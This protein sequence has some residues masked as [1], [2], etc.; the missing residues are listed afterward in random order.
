MTR[1][2][3]LYALVGLFM[4]NIKSRRVKVVEIHKNDLLAPEIVK[5]IEGEANFYVNILKNVY[6]I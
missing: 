4:E 5:I 2:E 3:V 1:L 6:I